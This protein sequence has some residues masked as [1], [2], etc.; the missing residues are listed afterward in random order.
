MAPLNV[1]DEGS[2]VIGR[3]FDPALATLRLGLM[4][5][6]LAFGSWL[7][8]WCGVRWLL[9]PSKPE[10]SAPLSNA[11]NAARLRRA[12]CLL[13]PLSSAT[14]GEIHGLLAAGDI[15]SPSGRLAVR[16]SRLAWVV[17][18]NDAVSAA[19]SAARFL[20]PSSSPPHL[21]LAAAVR[22]THPHPVT[23]IHHASLTS[24]RT[25]VLALSQQC[26]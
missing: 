7:Q 22:C 13:N 20:I 11:A 25:A 6:R 21:A 26:P 10:I 5:R 2:K 16:R 15:G 1:D 3:S 19:P 12:V 4:S 23:I 17:S 14:Y 18:Q 24:P 8:A 9:Q